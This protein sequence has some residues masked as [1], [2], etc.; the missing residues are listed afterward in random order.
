MKNFLLFIVSLFSVSAMCLPAGM[1]YDTLP[2]E[3]SIMTY[4]VKFLPRGAVYIH[5]HPVV[6]ARLIP[7]Q[8]MK[9]APDVIVFQE[10]F[11]GYADRVLRKKLKPMYPYCAG[12][13][14]RK[15]ISYKRAGGV[16]M[17]SKYPLKEIESITY[18]KCKGIDCIA[19]KGSLLVEVEHPKQKFQLLGTHMQAGGGNEIKK[20]QHDEAGE[21][22]KRHEEKGVPQFAAGD[23]NTHKVDT[24][25]YPHLLKAMNC[26]DS[27]I[28][29]DLKF[30]TDHLLNDMGNYNPA[31]RGVIDFVL[32]KANGFEPKQTTRSIIAFEQQWNKKHKSLSDHNA[33]MLRMKL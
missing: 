16:L 8:L 3:L 30:T 18:S 27:D 33:V 26:T 23:F 11:D 21:L 29:T 28:C 15:V 31:K 6:R 10:A 19:H 22:L 24:V 13:K 12:W 2:N 17:F 4:N 32:F 9:E 5:H 14:N 25:L 1:N 7:A 20:S